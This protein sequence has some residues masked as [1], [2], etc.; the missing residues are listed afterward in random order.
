MVLQRTLP[1]KDPFNLCKCCFIFFIKYHK[2]IL[3]ILQWA[4]GKG[5]W[6]E[7]NLEHVYLMLT[8]SKLYCCNGSYSYQVL[9][10]HFCVKLQ[11]LCF[12]CLVQPAEHRE[13][14][15]C[16]RLPPLTAVV[17]DGAILI[18]GCARCSLALQLM[19]EQQVEYR[20][21]RLHV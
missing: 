17:Y 8:C 4:R 20:S 6:L 3:N 1:A 10:C 21:L 14:D 2:Q 18:K 12:L 11:L 13:L 15:C 19:Q 5:R 9:I 16:V 7:D